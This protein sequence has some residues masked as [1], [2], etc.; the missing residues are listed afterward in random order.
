MHVCKRFGANAYKF[1]FCTVQPPYK[2]KGMC[3]QQ[4][5]F[6]LTVFIA[7]LLLSFEPPC[8]SRLQIHGRQH[9]EENG[10]H[11]FLRIWNYTCVLFDKYQTKPIQME[12]VIQ[13]VESQLPN[14]KS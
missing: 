13:L 11:L 1:D 3:L 5:F 7:V 12:L 8:R 14:E 9:E 2:N 6:R 10:H 4:A